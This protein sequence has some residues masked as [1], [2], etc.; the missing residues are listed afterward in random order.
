MCDQTRWL[1]VGGGWWHDLYLSSMQR[2]VTLLAI[3]IRQYT[4]PIDIQS[5]YGAVECF[6]IPVSDQFD[7]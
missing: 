3:V 6:F 4:F 2:L 7:V 5:Y 1:A